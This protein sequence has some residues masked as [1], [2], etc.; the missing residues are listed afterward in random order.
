LQNDPHELNNLIGRNPRAEQYRP[1]VARMKK[2]LVE[3]LTRVKSPDLESV[4]ARPLLAT[5]ARR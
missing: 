1:Q 5:P 3:W 4:K 2:L